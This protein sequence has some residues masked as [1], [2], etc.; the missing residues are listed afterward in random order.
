MR[1]LDASISALSSS[2]PSVTSQKLCFLTS[3]SN[4]PQETQCEQHCIR[5]RMEGPVAIGTL[6]RFVADRFLNE[7]IEVKAPKKIGKSV[8]VVGSLS[9]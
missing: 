7:E 8:A 2:K 9:F 1:H 3:A 6:E 5:A 4:S